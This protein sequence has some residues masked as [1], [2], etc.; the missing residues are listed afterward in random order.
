[1]LSE[2]R[3]AVANCSPMCF[4]PAN[5]QHKSRRLMSVS[6]AWSHFI[7]S[8]KVSVNTPWTLAQKEKGTVLSRKHKCKAKCKGQWNWWDFLWAKPCQST[9]AQDIFL[10][11]LI[12][13][14]F[15]LQNAH[16]AHLNQRV[17]YYSVLSLM[18]GVRFKTLHFQRVVLR[19]SWNFSWPPCVGTVLLHHNYT[20]SEICF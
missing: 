5:A 13:T 4:I 18:F 12:L 2:W 10:D 7:M 14:H 8:L 17:D 19:V 11:C 6:P 16:E 3:R 20:I 1:M 15:A 9:L